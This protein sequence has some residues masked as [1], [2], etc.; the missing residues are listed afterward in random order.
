MVEYIN[1]LNWDLNRF[2]EIG[3]GCGCILSEIGIRCQIKELYGVDI[4]EYAVENTKENLSKFGV[5]AE[6]F[7][8]DVLDAVPEGV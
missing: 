2:I 8:S 7:V 6:I 5:M 3:T 4:S 1:S